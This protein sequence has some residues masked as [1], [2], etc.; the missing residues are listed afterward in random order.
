MGYGNM[1][2]SRGD[3]AALLTAYRDYLLGTSFDQLKLTEKQHE[4]LQLYIKSASQGLT[5]VQISQITHGVLSG[6]LCAELRLV[7]KHIRQASK[8]AKSNRYTRQH[9][10]VLKKYPEMVNMVKQKKFLS[11]IETY[12]LRLDGLTNRCIFAK[13]GTETQLNKIKKAVELMSASASVA[14]IATQC[15]ISEVEAK[16]LLRLYIDNKEKEDRERIFNVNCKN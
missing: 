16:T 5:G 11:L 3:T 10:V 6:N 13:G 7:Q 14:E 4:H 8:I 12:R 2:N 15:K 9:K 1:L